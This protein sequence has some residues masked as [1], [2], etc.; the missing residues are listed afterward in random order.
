VSIAAQLMATPAGRRGLAAG[1]PAFFDT[2]YCGMRQAAHR[3]RW[4][5]LVEE[6]MTDARRTREKGRLLLLAPRDHG[7]TELAISVALRQICLNRDV[8]ILWISE[9]ATVATKR[10]RRLRALLTSAQVVEDWCSAPEVG[11]G[12]FRAGDETWT[13]TQVYVTRTL[14]STDG[15]IEAVGSGGAITGGHFDLILCDDLEDDRTTYT[16]AQR[17]KTRSWWAGT[18]LP[19]LTRGGLLAVIGTRKHAD[20]LYA[21]LKG[22]VLWRAIEDPAISTWPEAHNIVT[23]LDPATGD[24]IVDYVD[25]TGDSR[26]LWPEERPI[27][28]LMGERYAMGALFFAREFQHKVQDDSAAA[29]KWEWLELAK[30][31]GRGLWMGQLPPVD[32]LLLVQGWDLALVTDEDRARAQDSDYCVG[33]SWGKDEKNGDRYLVSGLRKRGMSPGRIRGEVLGEFEALGGLKK[34]RAVGVERN[35]FGEL[36][37]MGLKRTTDLPIKPHMTTGKQKADPWEGVPSLATLFENGKVVL[38]YHPDDHEGRAFVDILCAELWGLGREA[39]DD[40]VMALWIAECVL[41]GAGFQYRVAT[42][43]AI[44]E[45]DGTVYDG[46]SL[47]PRMPAPTPAEAEERRGSELWDNLGHMFPGADF[48]DDGDDDDDDADGA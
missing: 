33:I 48:E 17:E 37:Y 41:R 1:S 24:Q 42:G 5:D 31:R 14:Q 21:H 35:A 12:P 26:V 38:P 44:H 7:K 27:E 28:Y 45:T 29:F 9:S 32:A 13:N 47:G 36:H 34:V 20:D 4:L 39:H 11:C 8:R 19:M 6:T 30:K 10:V 40:T 22:D 3:R 18:V 25:V 16:Q 2:L 43:M 15:T 23:K 46:D